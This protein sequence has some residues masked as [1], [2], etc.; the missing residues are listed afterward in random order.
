MFRILSLDGGGLRGAF[1]AGFLAALERRVVPANG[2]P[3]AAHF[4]LLA[5]TSTGGILACGLASGLTAQ[6]LVQFYREQGPEIFHAREPFRPRTSVRPLYPLASRL[7]WQ[8]TGM[9]MD[10]LFRARY[11]P[12]HLADAF[13]TAFGDRT[14]GE[15][16]A[17][18]LIVPAV[19]LSRGRIHLFRTG[20]LP[21]GRGCQREL[22]LVDL[23]V[24]ATAAPT[25]FPHKVIDGEAYCDGGVWANNPTV[26]AVAEAVALTSGAAGLEDA[27][28]DRRSDYEKAVD[29]TGIEVL[30]LGTGRATYSLSPPG[31]DAGSLYWARHIA[32]VMGHSMQQGTELPAE[33]FLG[34][35]LMGVN[36]DL[37]DVTWRLDAADKLEA[38]FDLGEAAAAEVGDEAIARFFPAASAA[39]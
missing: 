35:R 7:F 29:V 32:D 3:L 22:K 6:R 23:L 37:P 5:G 33:F 39:V 8:K 34:D 9:P 18:R 1:G 38:L 31:A 13:V 21:G 30:S 12:F 26:L 27:A 24:A 14:L 10:E 2:K 25:Y 4:D 15:L 19:N 36:F 11:C 20:H 16:D 17:A 28:H